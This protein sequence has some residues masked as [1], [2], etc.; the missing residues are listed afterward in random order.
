MVNPAVA[1]T[2]G[3]RAPSSLV[4]QSMSDAGAAPLTTAAADGGT[5]TAPAV[6]RA[7]NPAAAANG[8]GEGGREG[9]RAIPDPVR[10]AGT[11]AAACLATGFTVADTPRTGSDRAVADEREVCAESVVR[12]LTLAAGGGV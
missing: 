6:D 8:D 5:G 2:D 12:R 7:G 1:T 10:A 9:V 4:R 11:A 3:A